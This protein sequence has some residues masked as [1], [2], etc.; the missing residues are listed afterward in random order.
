M[1]APFEVPN[2]SKATLIVPTKSF[3]LVYGLTNKIIAYVKDESILNTITFALTSVVSC[4]P[5]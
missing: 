3:L 1:Q 5:L 2:T 4:L